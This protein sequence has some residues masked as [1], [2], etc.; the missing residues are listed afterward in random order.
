[1]P[2]DESV[3]ALS[4]DLPSVCGPDWGGSYMEVSAD[5]VYYTID[6]LR[7]VLAQWRP[8]EGL[9]PDAQAAN[10]LTTATC[11]A[12][13]GLMHAHMADNRLDGAPELVQ[14]I[15]WFLSPQWAEERL[16]AVKVERERQRDIVEALLA[17][18]RKRRERTP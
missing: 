8:P 16:Q 2:A 9:E 7:C 4:L 12:L 14:R 6:V 11:Q 5:V 18:A 1:M 17:L 10:R 13:A 3:Y 15:D